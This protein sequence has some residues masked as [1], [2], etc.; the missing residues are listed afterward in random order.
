MDRNTYTDLELVHL[1]IQKR[2]EKAFGVLYSRYKIQVFS[3]CI[4]F[5]KSKEEAEDLCHDIFI[6]I[7]LK[8]STYKE[9]ASFSSWVY[10][11]T[12][13][14]CVDFVQK[15]YK[16]N[17]TTLELDEIDETRIKVF[18]SDI[19]EVLLQLKVE[20]LKEVL[21]HLKPED[22]M[23]LLLKYQDD[24]S[25]MELQEVFDKGESAIKM[26]LLR[27][28]ERA[29]EIHKSIYQEEIA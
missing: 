1:T 27:A 29:V 6:K 5:T 28:K 7:L 3:K 19:E 24:L 12:Y 22:K 21:D 18:H 20:H 17:E 16:T 10:A 9:K 8:L 2:D 25:I 4:S 23:I 11:I 13:N 15:K 14:S 26:K